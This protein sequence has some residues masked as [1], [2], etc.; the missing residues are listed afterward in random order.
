MVGPESGKQPGEGDAQAQ[1]RCELGSCVVH[2]LTHT[3]SHP[4][5]RAAQIYTLVCTPDMHT[6]LDTCAP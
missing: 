1:V 5:P 2:S 6:Y 3:S 4:H